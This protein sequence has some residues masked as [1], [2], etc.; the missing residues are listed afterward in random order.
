M[1]N[2]HFE[3]FYGMTKFSVE[4]STVHHNKAIFHIFMTRSAKKLLRTVYTE[5]KITYKRDLLSSDRNE[6]RNNS[7]NYYCYYLCA[8]WHKAADL[9]IDK[10]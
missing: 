4:K 1:R 6:S 2:Q 5:V 3:L 8:H 10:R 9:E 7:Q